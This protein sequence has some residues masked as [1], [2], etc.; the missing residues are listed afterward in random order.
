MTPSLRTKRAFSLIEIL[1]V[2]AI[3]SIL[4]GIGMKAFSGQGS[5]DFSKGLSQISGALELAQAQS[6]S[7]RTPIRLLIAMDN[8]DLVILSLTYKGDN[9]ESAEIINNNDDSDWAP[10][11]K[12]L[13]VKNMQLN[14]EFIPQVEEL[15]L[16]SEGTSLAIIQKVAGKEIQFDSMIQFS[17]Q[18]EASL[19]SEKKTTRGIQWGVQSLGTKPQKAVIRISSLTGRVEVLREEDFATAASSQ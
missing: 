12:P 18:G 17:S 3:M 2:L 11:A 19:N 13:I 4:M 9:S 15:S 16:L 8:Q 5:Q 7:T 14:E 1:V 6:L 10:T